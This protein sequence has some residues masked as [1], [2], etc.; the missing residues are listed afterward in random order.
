MT[1][2]SG[3]EEKREEGRTEKEKNKNKPVKITE[4]T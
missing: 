2:D 1:G 4:K 3:E